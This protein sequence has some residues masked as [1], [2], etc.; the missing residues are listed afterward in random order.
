MFNLYCWIQNI[1]PKGKETNYCRKNYSL[2]KYLNVVCDGSIIRFFWQYFSNLDKISRHWILNSTFY[3]TYAIVLSE[4]ES[5]RLPIWLT[6]ASIFGVFLFNSDTYKMAKLKNEQL[7]VKCI[8]A[9]W[10]N[11]TCIC[12]EWNSNRLSYK[13]IPNEQWWHYFHN[14]WLNDNLHL[15]QFTICCKWW[16]HNKSWVRACNI[17]IMFD[18]KIIWVCKTF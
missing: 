18:E 16:R 12:D 6:I 4:T 1:I 8:C 17:H 13:K 15:S 2:L 9:N 14:T 11:F 3:W 10:R 5:S 7:S